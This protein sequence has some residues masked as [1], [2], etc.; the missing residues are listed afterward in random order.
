MAEVIGLVGSLVGIAG[1]AGQLAQGSAFL[2]HFFNDFK[3][4][5]KYVKRILEELK[6]LESLLTSIQTTS[7][8]TCHDQQLE[9]AL[10]HCASCINEILGVVTANEQA[11]DL[12]ESKKTWKRFRFALKQPQ[13]S[14]YLLNLERAKS[15]LLQ[16]CANIAR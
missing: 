8:V 15:T 3:D 5:P 7:G 10:Q 1:F 2:Y 11:L 14:R 9:Q 16:S 6:L 13:I 4:A 12:K